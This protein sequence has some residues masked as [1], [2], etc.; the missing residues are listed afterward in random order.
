[1]KIGLVSDIKR[2]DIFEELSL[3]AAGKALREQGVLPVVLQQTTKKEEQREEKGCLSEFAAEQFTICAADEELLK[4]Y[5]IFNQLQGLVTFAPGSYP[6]KKQFLLDHPLLLT[7]Q[8]MLHG[9]SEKPEEEE[10]YLFADIKELTKN[11][12]RWICQYAKKRGLTKVILTDG[13]KSSVRRLNG[14]GVKT[15]ETVWAE[16]TEVT[17]EQYLGYVW[18][19]A[20]VVIDHYAG[21][22]LAL[23]HE[24]EFAVFPAAEPAEEKKQKEI[25]EQLLLTA[26]LADASA[27][28]EREYVIEQPEEFRRG[29]RNLREKLRDQ[30]SEG[31]DLDAGEMLVKTP[32]RLSVSQCTGCEAC[33]AVCPEGAIRMEENAKGFLYPVV[34][35]MRCNECDWCT[36]VCIKRGR[37]QLV[38]LSDEREQ[39]IF[40]GEAKKPEGYTAYSGL[41][42]ELVRFIREERNG[43]I[44]GSVLN[45]RLE[46][47]IIGTEDAAVA[48]QFVEQHYMKSRSTE[49]FR[50]IRALLEQGRFVMFVGLTCECA[51]LRGY[52]KKSYPKLFLCDL[53]CHAVMSEKLFRK[54][55]EYI[56]AV[57]GAPVKGIHFGAFPAQT[58]QASRVIQIELEGK[59][60]I[61]RKYSSNN[62]Y[63]ILEQLLPIREGCA[64]CSYTPTKRAGD[65]TLG[66]LK[67]LGRGGI[68]AK[69]RNYSIIMANSDKGSRV[70]GR[71]AEHSVL[72]AIDHD[73]LIKYQYKKRVP[74][75]K[76]QTEFF[77]RLEKQSFKELM[78]KK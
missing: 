54:Y 37:R 77:R 76:E 36:D 20:A 21:M 7:N 50:Q 41:W 18:M 47:E 68:P 9:I 40:V 64:N 29:V 32:V 78:R 73:T 27:E 24:K 1:M 8:V 25:L 66:E 49:A 55:L 17:A 48:Q 75:G 53:L 61:R 69:W 23:L 16:L 63:R 3:W 6:E 70:L 13:K 67:E 39:Q 10:P 38:R 5:G 28:P 58:M 52:L 46:P 34:D 51:G 62:Y 15:D 43:I 12:Y 60:T 19:A 44:F 11:K 4:R 35:P 72:T 14:L 2:A 59:D 33:A 74:Y 26:Q 56:E 42:E 22:M 45:E 71:I 30:M 31:L 57:E 65:I